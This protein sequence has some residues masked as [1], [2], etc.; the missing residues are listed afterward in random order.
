MRCLSNGDRILWR[1]L[2][3]AFLLTKVA[4]KEKERRIRQMFLEKRL[5]I[6]KEM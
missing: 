3:V 2:R 5:Q 1:N 4:L 6:D